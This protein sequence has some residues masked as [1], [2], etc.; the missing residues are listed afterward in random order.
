MPAHLTHLLYA[1][2]CLVAANLSGSDDP[3]VAVGS[4]GPDLFY[5]NRRSLP[6]GLHYGIAIHRSRYGDL[7]AAMVEACR[8]RS[9]GPDSPTGLFVLS[10]AGHAAADRHLHP[11]INFFSG[12]HEPGEDDTRRY[13]HMHAF[14]ERVID[15]LL[16]GRYLRS[17]PE[18]I[19][20]AGIFDHGENLPDPI[21]QVFA[22]AMAATYRK[23]AKDEDLARKIRNAYRDSRGY[24]RFTN[25][26]GRNYFAEAL[27]REEAGHMGD[28]WI[29]LVHPFDLPTDVDFANESGTAWCHPAHEELQSNASLWEIYEQACIDGTKMTDALVRTWWSADRSELAE[30]VGNS[31]LS[32]TGEAVGMERYRFSRPLDLPRVVEWL[33]RAAAG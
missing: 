9:I 26:P 4:Q 21:P 14:F 10:F 30:V 18:E 17:T 12:W 23:A 32:D 20:F 31:N 2:H 1:R 5:H 19:D 3:I 24:Y 22:E 33:R 29:T 7:I 27:L 8:K 13:R 25:M 11:F 15:R 28:R 16:I 6:S